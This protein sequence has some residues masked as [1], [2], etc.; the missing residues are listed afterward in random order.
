MK[1]PKS[2][3]GT[4]VSIFLAETGMTA[5]ELAAGAKVKRTTL[6]AAMAGRTPGHDLVPAVD[7]Y[8]DSYYRK[9]AAAR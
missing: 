3:F 2:E 7:A 5:E 8:I 4:K 6:V 1:K 9:E